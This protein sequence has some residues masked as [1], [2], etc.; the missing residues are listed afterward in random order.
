MTE[1]EEFEFRLRYEQEQAPQQAQEAPQQPEIAQPVEEGGYFTEMAKNIPGSAYD[2][3]KSMVHA[4]TSPAETINTLGEAF[5]G[6]AENL[7]EAAGWEKPEG[8]DLSDVGRYSKE[9][10][11][12]QTANMLGG[13]Y[14]ERYGSLEKAKE[15][16]KEDPVGALLDASLVTTGAG[17]ALAAVPKAGKLS[18][19]VRNVAAAMDPVNLAVAGA[20]APA[21]LIP[22][23][24]KAA[25]T[26]AVANLLPRHRLRSGKALSEL[27]GPQ[28]PEI[29]KNLEYQAQALPGSQPTA[30]QAALG[31]GR[32]GPGGVGPPSPPITRPQ[33]AA[34]EKPMQRRKPAAHETRMEEQRVARASAI[35]E[36]IARSP[37]E[38][39]AAVKARKDATEPM[40][41][42]AEKSTAPVDIMPVIDKMDAIIAANPGNKRLLKEMESL[43]NGLYEGKAP[44][45]KANEIISSIE[46]L[47]TTMANQKNA[48]I[49]RELQGIKMDLIDSVP[50]YKSADETFRE[51]SRPINQ[52]DIGE[53]LVEKIRPIK[54]D[55][56]GSTK[57]INALENARL[58]IKNSLGEPRY[59]SLEEILD[60]QQQQILASARSEINRDAVIAA[61]G[62]KGYGRMSEVL[63]SAL[64]PIE[65]PGML[66]SKMM[67]ARNIMGRLKGAGTAQTMKYMADRQLS[68]PEWAAMMKEATQKEKSIMGS[69]EAYNKRILVNQALFQSGRAAEE[70]R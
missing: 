42:A 46:G 49:K 50:M 3:G 52:M 20:K 54:G 19:G 70:N 37:M 36:G 41:A 25:T 62:K 7:A 6:G 56:E 66:S 43:K 59:K 22:E 26:G 31:G 35:Q 5:F 48:Y 18:Q 10:D 28:G 15:T 30:I 64:D 57:Y 38:K 34:L 68:A 58:T 11:L 17:G 33:F 40:Y 24:V 21:A 29:I 16:F 44:R 14:K 67:V 8:E 9:A 65:L 1:E 4:I 53:H 45:T 69:R 47:K 23:G 32:L 39:R 60:P 51:M 55:V 63:E 27:A 61:S 2:V 13:V 12:Q